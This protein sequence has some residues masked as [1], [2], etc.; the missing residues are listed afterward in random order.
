MLLVKHGM[1]EN[2]GKGVGV[3]DDSS[4]LSVSHREDG[5]PSDEMELAMSGADFWG[6]VSPV[7]RCESPFATRA[8]AP[9][10]HY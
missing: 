6:D 7:L 8:A 2:K 1:R 3:K 5:V 4:I 9:N 10:M